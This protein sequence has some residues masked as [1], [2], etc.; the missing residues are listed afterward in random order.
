M[1]RFLLVLVALVAL[2]LGAALLL[3]SSD[4][5]DGASSGDVDRARVASGDGE[6]V[7][8]YVDSDPADTDAQR[9]VEEAALAES[10]A[11]SVNAEVAL[12]DDLTIVM[13]GDPEGPYYDPETRTIEY[14]WQFVTES[15]RLL[16]ESDYAGADLETGVVDATRFVLMHE[17]GHA[18]VDLLDLP[19]LGREEDAADGFAAYAAVEYAEDGELAIAASDL[20]AAFDAEDPEFEEADFFDSHALDLQRFY[21]I[22]CLVYG[23]DPDA[24]AGVVEGLD[25]DDERLD[26]CP[27]EWDQVARSWEQVLEPHLR[28]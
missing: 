5:D 24:Y 22:S 13:G 16:A 9:L 7:V 21:A 20:F 4:G 12:P 8:E 17:V 18:L 1:R 27:V 19:V 3:G 25:F 15:R 28:A 26:E 23:A 14:P 2:A 6:V 11:D 10:I